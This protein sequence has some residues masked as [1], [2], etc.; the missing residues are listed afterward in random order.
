MIKYLLIFFCVVCVFSCN[1]PTETAKEKIVESPHLVNSNITTVPEL[2]LLQYF[3]IKDA[4]F[5]LNENWQKVGTLVSAQNLKGDTVSWQVSFINAT[6]NS[7]LDVQFFPN[8]NGQ[9]LF[10][11]KENNFA[12]KSGLYSTHSEIAEVNGIKALVGSQEL[13]INGKGQELANKQEVYV[14]DFMHPK[15]TG[16]F[17]L[18]YKYNANF[19]NEQIQDE[20]NAFLQTL[21]IK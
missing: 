15:N 13:L 11:A 5:Q 20:F 18:Q 8:P 2:S 14:I 10:K 3:Q 19:D 9:T 21:E 16:M 4:K 12:L 7:T 1:A 6:D 17:E